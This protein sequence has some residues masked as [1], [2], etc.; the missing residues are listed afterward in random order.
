MIAFNL[1]D[2]AR[3]ESLS[4]KPLLQALLFCRGSWIPPGLCP[5]LLGYILLSSSNCFPLRIQASFPFNWAF[6][7]CFRGLELQF[8]LTVVYVKLIYLAAVALCQGRGHLNGEA[9]RQLI[10][11]WT[12]VT[13]ESSLSASSNHI[14]YKGFFLFAPFP[15]FDLEE[16]QVYTRDGLGWLVPKRVSLPCRSLHLLKRLKYCHCYE[17]SPAFTS[18]TGR[19]WTY[20]ALSS[21][22]CL[23]F[24]CWWS[25]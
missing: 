21:A 25:Q 22:L 5:V 17:C 3:D 6:Q 23:F 8:C 13:G 20:Q 24:L 10:A 7:L 19:L 4:Y 1:N 2:R 14:C 15:L 12:A 18:Q 11:W 16:Y 9:V